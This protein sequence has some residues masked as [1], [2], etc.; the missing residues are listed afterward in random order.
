MP[1]SC[2]S[3]TALCF[4]FFLMIRRPPRSTLFPYTT[5]FRSLTK[6]DLV[7]PDWLALVRDD[8]ATLVRAT[9]LEGAPILAVSAKTGDGLAELRAALRGLAEVVEPRSLDQLPRLPIDRVFT[10]RGFGTVVTGTLTAGRLAGDDPIPGYPEGG[11]G[12]SRGLP[13]HGPPV[14]EAF[15]RP[16]TPIKPP[17]AQTTAL[18][19]SA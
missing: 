1:V 15:A 11:G 16:R 19:L 5:L 8:V 3:T 10:V 14:P 13:T 4:F 12:K 18:D 9:F 17:R 7:E 2:P 6:T